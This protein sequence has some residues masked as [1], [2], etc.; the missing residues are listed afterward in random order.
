MRIRVTQDHIDHGLRGSATSDPVA[1]ALQ[2]EGFIRPYV[3][4]DL[5]WVDG[6]NGGFMRQT[7]MTPDS[8]VLFMKEFDN[9]VSVKPF[10]FE[11]KF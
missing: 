2:D 9:G 4:P 8:V 10:Q 1:L 7:T 6:R 5:I 11:V 3:G